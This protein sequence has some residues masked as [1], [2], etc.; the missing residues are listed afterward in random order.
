MTYQ[1]ETIL[2]DLTINNPTFCAQF[3]SEE[4]ALTI[5]EGADNKK[6]DDILLL[7]VAEVSYLA[8]YFVI[9]TGFS[10][11]QVKAIYH[12]IEDL[13]KEK[14]G[15][16]PLRVEGQSEG[17]WILLD[18]GDVIAH[19]MLPQDRDYYKIES[20]WGHAQ[21]IRYQLTVDN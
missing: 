21:Q 3:T 13:V 18:Y 14:Y 15:R 2:P 4:L 7:N 20:F 11:T 9:I 12:S 19:I 1:Q 16:S 6:G 5:A 17:T 8:D 10:R